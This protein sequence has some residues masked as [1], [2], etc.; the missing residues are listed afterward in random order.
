MR[1]EVGRQEDALSMVWPQD[2]SLNDNQTFHSI[3]IE[4]LLVYF[5]IWYYSKSSSLLFIFLAYDVPASTGGISILPP[6]HIQ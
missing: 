3:N 2:E 1:M 6:N 5:F 4:S